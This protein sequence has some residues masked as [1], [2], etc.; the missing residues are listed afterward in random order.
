M[1]NRKPKLKDRTTTLAVNAIFCEFVSRASTC[2]YCPH[3]VENCDSSCFLKK[4]RNQISLICKIGKMRHEVDSAYVW[5]S[6]WSET[7]GFSLG[8]CPVAGQLQRLA[9]AL[10]LI[11]N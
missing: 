9:L 6:V 11:T 2:D 4:N 1:K 3:V 8:S 5:F 7:R 10:S